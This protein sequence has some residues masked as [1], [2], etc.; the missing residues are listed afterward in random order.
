MVRSKKSPPSLRSDKR[1]TPCAR[2]FRA[3][4]RDSLP[5]PLSHRISGSIAAPQLAAGAAVVTAAFSRQRR[6]CRSAHETAQRGLA[7]VAELSRPARLHGFLVDAWA[8]RRWH[9]AAAHFSDG[10]SMLGQCPTRRR[11]LPELEITSRATFSFIAGS[12]AG[13]RPPATM[14]VNA[15]RTP[16]R[17]RSPAPAV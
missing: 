10:F 16:A 14:P 5:R 12:L 6:A 17:R 11:F 13:R 9:H 3:R 15:S 7:G 8:R 2:A 1:I 4:G